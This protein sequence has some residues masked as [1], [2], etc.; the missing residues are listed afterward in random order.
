M[1]LK[2]E[3]NI[4][5]LERTARIAVVGPLAQSRENMPGTWSVATDLTKPRTLVEGLRAVAGDRAEIVWARGSNIC[6]DP[7]LEKNSTMFGRDIP[8]DGRTDR[9]MLDEALRIAADA[10]VVI[11]ALGEPS[12]MS[13]E[14]SSRS[15]IGIPDAQQELL[16]ELVATGKPVV[17]VLFAGRPMTITWEAEHV[18]AILNVWFGGT[19]AAEAIADVLFGDVNPSGKLPASFP[20]SVGQIPLYYNHKNTGRPLQGNG[21]EKFRSN[22]L[23]VP[24]T[25]LYPFGYGLSYTVF[26]Y[27]PLT[28]SADRMTADGSVEASV[29]VTNAGDRDGAEVVQLYLRDLVGSVTRPVQELKAFEKV[30]LRAGETKRVTFRI[31]EPMLRFYNHALEFVSE[32]GEFDV[33][34]GGSSDRVQHATFTLE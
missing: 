1:L 2:N 12:E 14:S 7:V 3:A 10:D 21:F 4:L 30:M 5:P 29:E 11:A 19:E 9:E 31:D 33:M 13:G 22:Y 28:L 16:R 27:G 34:V 24:N 32:P 18:P 26:E 6:H 17:L 23:D 15:Q 20:R 25:P 8:R